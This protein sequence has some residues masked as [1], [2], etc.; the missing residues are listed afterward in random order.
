[1]ISDRGKKK[2]LNG[3][4][5]GIGDKSESSTQTLRMLTVYRR[6]KT[7]YRLVFFEVGLFFD[8]NTTGQFSIWHIR[9]S[10]LFLKVF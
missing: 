1:M 7:M 4:H 8:N 5:T 2:H 9:M 3:D 6:Q 10:K